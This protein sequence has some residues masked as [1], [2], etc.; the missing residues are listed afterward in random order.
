MTKQ[1]VYKIYAVAHSRNTVG[2]EM[3]CDAASFIEKRKPD[4]LKIF[5]QTF[6]I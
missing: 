1:G 4:E 6:I 5:T 2:C 3:N